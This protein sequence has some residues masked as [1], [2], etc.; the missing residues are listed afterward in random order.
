MNDTNQD[1]KKYFN[2]I[3]KTKGGIGGTTYAIALIEYLREKYGDDQVLVLDCDPANGRTFYTFCQNGK[4]GKPLELQTIKGAKL[5]K[6]NDEK[7][8]EEIINNVAEQPR[9]VV[10]DM[11]SNAK[12]SYGNTYDSPMKFVN[13]CKEWGYE[14]Y[15]HD[16]LTEDDETLTSKNE[17]FHLFGNEVNYVTVLN[18]NNLK[19]KESNEFVFKGTQKK[20]IKNEEFSSTLTLIKNHHFIEMRKINDEALNVIKSNNMKYSA[21]AENR[22]AFTNFQQLSLRDFRKEIFLEFDKAKLFE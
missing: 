17:N 5:I 19:K 1:Q 15:V 9:F 6:I 18:R 10:L 21:Y 8:R 14:Y 2:V 4:D 13:L 16:L 12:D 3:L 22:Q 20:S 7:E 11:G